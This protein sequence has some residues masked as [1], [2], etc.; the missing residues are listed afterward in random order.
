MATEG[1]Q[2]T[3]LPGASNR[4]EYKLLRSALGSGVEGSVW[5]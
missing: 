1:L 2:H 3:S 4:I 5:V